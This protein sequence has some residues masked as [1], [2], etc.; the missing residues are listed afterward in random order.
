MR[1]LPD[2]STHKRLWELNPGHSDVESQCPIHYVTCSH[3]PKY[4]LEVLFV[5][6]I[7]GHHK[8]YTM[9]RIVFGVL[10]VLQ[11]STLVLSCKSAIPLETYSPEETFAAAQIIIYGKYVR[12]Y[13][14]APEGEAP[15]H[16]SK[17]VI[18]ENYCT[19]RS[20]NVAVPSNLTLNGNIMWH[21]C[22][23]SKLEPGTSYLF[24]LTRDESDPHGFFRVFEPNVA[25]VGTFEPS[26]ENFES[27]AKYCD[28]GVKTYGWDT[29]MCPSTCDDD[30]YYGASS[31][32][33][34]LV[35]SFLLLAI[36]SILQF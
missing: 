36:V 34:V 27:A 20:G 17:H 35:P 25:S 22:F 23:H 3:S 11:C 1:S 16:S 5:F 9:A 26:A 29:G 19:I 12:D 28:A 32:P 30:G 21:S 2:T 33:H 6:I 8:H 4:T 18:V 24:A 13:T 15:P 10:L 14:G 7:S 31:G